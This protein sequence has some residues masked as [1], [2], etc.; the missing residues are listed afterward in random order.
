MD[1]SK[2]RHLFLKSDTFNSV[3][4]TVMRLHLSFC[5]GL[6]YISSKYQ[7]LQCKL[8]P[9]HTKTM[10]LF[11]CGGLWRQHVSISSD[12]RLVW[13]Q[14]TSGRSRRKISQWQQSTSQTKRAVLSALKC[15]LNKTYFWL[16][17]V[18]LYLSKTDFKVC[19]QVCKCDFSLRVG[20][21]RS[22]VNNRCL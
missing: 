19:R 4:T 7:L 13:D 9:W 16:I 21:L 10:S 1:S 3:L 18:V 22:W 8:H 11:G 5:E 17:I 12:V 20:K 6:S 2:W 14:F 15:I